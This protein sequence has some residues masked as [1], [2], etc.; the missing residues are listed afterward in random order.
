MSASRQPAPKPRPFSR[1]LRAITEA[2]NAKTA[3]WRG[4]EKVLMTRGAV[5]KTVEELAPR[6]SARNG[7]YTRITRLGQRQGDAAEMVQ[8]EL[9]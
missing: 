6:Y 4:L 7:G 3:P 2:K 1:L 5:K 9:V 8:I